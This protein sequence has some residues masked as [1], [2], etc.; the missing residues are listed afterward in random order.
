MNFRMTLKIATKIAAVTVAC[1]SLSA[2]FGSSTSG[3]AGVGGVAGSS[4]YDTNFAAAQGKL[5]T[6]T[7]LT[8]SADYKG[9]I[10][11][12][13]GLNQGN[14]DESVI[15][16]LEMNVNFDG[17]SRPITATASGFEGE[18]N[19]TQVTV[20]GTLSTANAPNG[21]NAVTATTVEVPVVGSVV[22]TGLS[23]QLE[24]SLSEETEQLTGDAQLTLQGTFVGTEG[25][26]VFGS[27]AGIIDPATGPNVIT[28]GT[29]YA[30]KD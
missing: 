2:C 27:A 14:A 7:A 12:L 25:A 6:T 22:S 10:E 1:T 15:G 13:T 24:G 3:V 29:W 16:D 23:V 8:G 20:D 28:G 26:S 30:D 18:V 19:G 4:D 21:I 9:E 5:A 17:G 11:I